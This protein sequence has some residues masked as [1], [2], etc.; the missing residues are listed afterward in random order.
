M[1]DQRSRLRFIRAL[2]TETRAD[3]RRWASIDSVARRVGIEYEEAEA[4]ATELEAAGLLWVRVHSIWLTQ[5]GR[6]L[7]KKP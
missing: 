3:V 2:D 6:Q 5:V 4:L 1:A 7:V